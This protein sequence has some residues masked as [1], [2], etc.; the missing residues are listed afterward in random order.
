[1]KEIEQEKMQK[2]GEDLK[3]LDFI[4]VKESEWLGKQR[5]SELE[6]A[7]SRSFMQ[8]LIK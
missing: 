5:S 1:M 2:K 8:R 7:L 3:L 4:G 6:K